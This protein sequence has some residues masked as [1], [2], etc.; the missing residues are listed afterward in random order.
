MGAQGAWEVA[1]GRSRRWPLLLAALLAPALVVLVRGG[2]DPGGDAAIPVETAAP[3]TGDASPARSSPRPE[4]PPATA[5]E[6][7]WE[8]LGEAPVATPAEHHA[9]WTGEELVVFG[10]GDEAAAYDPGAAGW[11]VLPEPPVARTAAPAPLWTGSSVLVWGAPDPRSPER[12]AVAAYDPAA[13]RWREGATGPLPAPRTGVAV[14]TGREALVWGAL[15]SGAKVAAAYDPASDRWSPLPGAP[16]PTVEAAAGTWTGRELVVWGERV[17][18]GGAPFAAA[19]D[20]AAYS[21][22]RL[23]APPLERPSAAAASWTGRE[24]VLWGT[25]AR[26]TDGGEPAGGALRLEEPGAAW[27]E[28][29]PPPPG[30]LREEHGQVS[31][32]AAWTG[33]RVAVVGTTSGV[34]GW[35]LDPGTGTWRV[36]PGGGGRRLDPAMAWTGRELLVWGG[37]TSGGPAVDL[38][39]WRPERV[40]DAGR[41]DAGEAASSEDPGPLPP[42]WSRSPPPPFDRSTSGASTWNWTAVAAGDQIVVLPA[43]GAAAHAPLPAAALDLLSGEWT[44]LPEAP[45]AARSGAAVAWTGQ[46]VLVW[47]GGPVP[48]AGGATSGRLGDGAAYHPASRSWRRLP[49]APVAAGTP[50]ASTWTGEE[51]L[52]WGLPER[53]GAGRDAG[54]A[55]HPGSNTWRRIAEAPFG[56]GGGGGAWTGRELVVVG[57]ARGT[58]VSEHARAVAYDPA[59]DSWR[60]LP[61]WPLSP[62][63][64]TVAGAAGLA[65]A[66]DYLLEAAAYDPS[67]DTWTALPE[68]PVRPSECYPASVR[69]G[70]Y[71]FAWYCGQAALLDPGEATWR[72]VELPEGAGA[73]I[74][75]SDG[76]VH[77]LAPDGAVLTFRP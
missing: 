45:V 48:W 77:A 50:Y 4:P 15:G 63:A 8:P 57:R 13:R 62:Q 25:P 38:E 75:G 72:A 56:L 71:V 29:G 44:C 40:V 33:E 42:G 55:Y 21:W 36:L 22:R 1:G 30:G 34:P 16:V 49:P 65:V 11:V 24:L 23:P 67:T 39:A 54:A 46:E 73:P 70:A 52:L 69:A 5:A 14:W 6:G 68:P 43:I 20:P 51:F 7:E 37:Y 18:F 74:A 61:G 10:D 60:T 59:A 58:D 19:Y 31:A 32:S 9:V 2:D 64:T 17:G 3:G 27:R 28:L 12:L 53:A 66:W 41:C 76:A 26:G 47:G 35:T